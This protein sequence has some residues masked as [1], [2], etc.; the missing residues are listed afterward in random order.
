MVEEG[1]C[2]DEMRI[3][4]LSFKGARTFILAMVSLT[5]YVGLTWKGMP[6]EGLKELALISFGF[7]FAKTVK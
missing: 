1:C 7:F 4:A 5:A 3:G 6:A 2:K